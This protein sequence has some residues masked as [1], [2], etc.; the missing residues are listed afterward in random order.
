MALF[1]S[2]MNDLARNFSLLPRLLSVG[3]FK[4][5]NSKA[6][7]P[8]SHSVWLLELI[9][10]GQLE[11]SLQ[12]GS[13]LP[14]PAGT[15]VLYAP[16]TTYHEK[17]PPRSRACHSI[18]LLFEMELLPRFGAPYFLVRDDE[19]LLREL[20]EKALHHTGLSV[21]D[22]LLAAGAFLSLLA[23]LLQAEAQGQ[24]LSVSREYSGADEM[25]ANTHRFMRAHLAQ[26]ISLQQLASHVG[27]SVSGFAHAYK[28][29]TGISP[30]TRL[31]QMRIET[32]KFYLLRERSPLSQIARETGFADAFHLSRAF[33][34]ATGASPR[35]FRS[36][37]IK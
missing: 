28:R 14:L 6:D 24:T 20:A 31:R 8:H 19:K 13:W 34:R 37:Q 33:K 4:M 29:S 5:T 36:N 17:T 12:S 11:I 32:A 27:L 10:A 7:A 23:H 2:N 26:T 35:Q 25:I 22:D 30:M 21:A 18:A 1:A 16:H 15:G 9:T 3:Q